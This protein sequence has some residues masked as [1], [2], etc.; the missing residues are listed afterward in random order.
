MTA[1]EVDEM[2]NDDTG[3]GPGVV[4]IVKAPKSHN[5]SKETNSSGLDDGINR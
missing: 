2:P 5:V 1:S 3:S 4:A